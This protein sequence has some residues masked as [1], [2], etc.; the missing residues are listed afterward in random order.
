MNEARIKRQVEHTHEQLLDP[1]VFL[2]ALLCS[3]T[4]C[5]VLLCF[6]YPRE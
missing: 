6:L 3:A 1:I 2:L 5:V 4:V